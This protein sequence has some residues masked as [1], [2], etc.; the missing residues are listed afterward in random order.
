MRSMKGHGPGRVAATLMMTALLTGGNGAAAGA[1]D[2]SPD[3]AGSPAAPGMASVRVVHA[4]PDAPA[5][6]VFVDGEKAISG[7]PFGV[8]TD[9]MP[10]PAGRHDF[11]VVPAGG[12]LDDAVIEVDDAA[13]ADEGIYEIAAVGALAT[14]EGRIYEVDAAPTTPDQARFRL[15]H[16]APDAPTVDIATTAGP[17]LMGGTAFG[18][19]S[20]YVAVDPGLYDLEVRPVG[21][22]E[23]AL[24]LPNSALD[25][26]TVYDLFAVG[27]LADG[28]L[29]ALVVATPTANG[30]G[31]LGS[32]RL[33]FDVADPS[34]AFT[35]QGFARRALSTPTGRMVYYEK[36]EG[37]PL[38]FLHG[39][40]GGA[41]SWQWSKVAPAF[42]DRYRV[43]VPDFV[44]WGSAEHPS[45]FLLFDDYAAQVDALL[46]ALGEPAV[47]VAS[48]LASGFAADAA[49]ADPERV[50]ALIMITPSGG[51]DFGGSSL[52]SFY[53]ETLQ[54]VAQSDVNTRAYPLI[55]WSR[56]FTRLYFEGD[57]YADP[58]AVGDD[59]VDA[60]LWSATRPGAEYSALPFLAGDAS[61]DLAP[62]LRELAVPAAMV[63]GAEEAQVGVEVRDRF[64]ALRPDLPL[65]TMP[66]ASANPE[67]ELPAQTAALIA[68]LIGELT[69]DAES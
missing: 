13:L 42:A 59:V 8:A 69:P 19:A 23:V 30:F 37:R 9:P 34:V 16:A 6:D 33:A 11:A 60:F 25:P 44:G 26:G 31:A 39:I 58:R 5:V 17:I 53:S 12:A 45:R 20:A 43:I 24:A 28:S 41:S 29:S 56:E 65:V 52:P 64:A 32:T 21:T 27:R 40:G 48:S 38:V 4:S 22:E 47:V 49:L 14:I 2:V 54:P 50:A 67:L 66:R 57:G 46:A 61:Y 35:G 7:L 55:F 36:G 63:Y 68:R 1:Q 51:Q 18:E 10:L 3:R 62:L 15:I